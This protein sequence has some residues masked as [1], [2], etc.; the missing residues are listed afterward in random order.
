M[1]TDMRFHLTKALNEYL[2]KISLSDPQT[3]KKISLE[4]QAHAD[5][6]TGSLINLAEL[7]ELYGLERDGA[8]KQ[9]SNELIINTA[10]LI[11]SVLEIAKTFEEIKEGAK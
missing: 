7:L 5:F 3:A 9:A 4:M 8:G 10:F 11:K 1:I 2:N 6:L